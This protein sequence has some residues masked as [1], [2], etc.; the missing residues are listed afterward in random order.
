MNTALEGN[1]PTFTAYL[2]MQLSGDSNTKFFPPFSLRCVT[3]DYN[4]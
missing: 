1:K 4:E 3:E 2:P